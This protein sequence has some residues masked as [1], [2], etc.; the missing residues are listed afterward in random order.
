MQKDYTMNKHNAVPDREFQQAMK[1]RR[2]VAEQRRRQ[3]HKER[4]SNDSASKVQRTDK[5][6]SK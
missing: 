1:E 2:R 5:Q 3:E 4:Q 6:D